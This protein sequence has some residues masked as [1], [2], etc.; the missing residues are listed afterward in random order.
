MACTS[1]SRAPWLRPTPGMPSSGVHHRL[2][3]LHKFAGTPTAHC[4]AACQHFCSTPR[5]CSDTVAACFCPF[6]LAMQP[7]IH[8]L[9]L[10]G[11]LVSAWGFGRGTA[12]QPCWCCLLM[13]PAQLAHAWF[14]RVEGGTGCL[15][16]VSLLHL[17]CHAGTCS[18]LHGCW[19]AWALPSHLSQSPCP[20]SPTSPP[21]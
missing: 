5:S 8:S 1:S 9:E 15:M 6:N 13:Q 16:P 3:H 4:S 12:M 10:Y 21:R 2:L 11:H 7:G 19:H 20:C 18:P 17:T 14:D